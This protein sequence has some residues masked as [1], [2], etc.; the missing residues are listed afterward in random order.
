MFFHVSLSRLRAV[1]GGVVGMSVGHVRVV[2]R[3]LVV[4]GGMVFRGF[5]VVLGC[6]LVML[7]RLSVVLSRFL[8]HDKTL[9]FVLDRGFGARER[10][11]R[12]LWIDR[13]A[14]VQFLIGSHLRVC[15]GVPRRRE[16]PRR[17]LSFT[18]SLDDVSLLRPVDNF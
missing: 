6:V 1:V 3:L 9:R 4:A 2:S 12:P 14:S 7:R 10:H 5:P 17:Y 13:R 8:G 11:G 18:I 15:C 16:N